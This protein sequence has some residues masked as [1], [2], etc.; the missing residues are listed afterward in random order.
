MIEDAPAAW[1][2]ER[3]PWT[4]SRA[5]MATGPKHNQKANPHLKAAFL[6]VV[7]NQL[8]AND[9]P[10]TRETFNRLVA[11]GI[12]EGDAKLYIAQAVCVETFDILKH[13]RPFNLQRYVKNLARLPEPP[14]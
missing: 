5:M 7:D 6:E 1:A 4:R 11:Q 8:K 13:K 10:E 2:A 9:P 3:I 14:W 12:S